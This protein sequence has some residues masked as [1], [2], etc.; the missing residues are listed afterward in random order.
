MA[1]ASAAMRASPLPSSVAGSAHSSASRAG[2][3][4]RVEAGAFADD[5]GGPPFREHPGFQGGQGV[6]HLVHQGGGE[7]EV[8]AAAGR[9]V[10]SG[11]G[12]FAGQATA[13]LAAGTRGRPRRRARLASGCA[14]ALA[15][16]A[17]AAAFGVSSSPMRAINAASSAAGSRYVSD[18]NICSTIHDPIDSSAESIGIHELRCPAE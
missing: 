10:A 4:P 15:W 2:A 1:L 8:A 11:Q 9:G 3:G 13:A 18:S 7:A 17:A 12:D 5:Q 6:R 16:A 14:V